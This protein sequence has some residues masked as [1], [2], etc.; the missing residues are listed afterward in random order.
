M[1]ISSDLNQQARQQVIAASKRIVIKVGS[2]LLNT[3]GHMPK[4]QRIASLIAQIAQIRERKYEVILVTSGAISTGMELTGMKSRPRQ[5]AM[6]QAMA[7]IGQSRLMSL[8]EQECQH[9]GFHCGQ[10]LLSY[11]DLHD[12]KKH[13]NFRNCLNALLTQRVL[14]VIN[15][16]DTVSTDE[17]SFGDNDKLA[18]LV[19]TMIHAQLTILLTS[20][21]GLLEL[22]DK[23]GRRVPLVRAITGEIRSLAQGPDGNPHSIGGMISKIDAAEICLAA[24]ENL[25]I[26][27][28]RD[29][30][31][32]EKILDAHDVG[33]LFMPSTARVPGAKRW[34][35]FFSEPAGD[36]TIDAGAVQALQKSGKS[37]LPSGIIAI[38]GDFDQGDTINI[39]AASGAVIAMGITNYGAADIEKIK[40]QKSA[41]IATILGRCDYD[42]VVHRDNMVIF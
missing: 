27:D 15:E 17:I 13:L 24:G 37:L 9:H 25:W 26:A 28:G 32:L 23:E 12:R 31:I 7:S 41:R 1:D 18:A 42:E 20:V 33:T 3:T 22:N 5:I 34:L 16:N 39:I 36:I 29:F 6:L 14:P 40:G 35:A 10:I 21:E 8:Y 11:D 4:K 19:A 2:R 38:N 30:A